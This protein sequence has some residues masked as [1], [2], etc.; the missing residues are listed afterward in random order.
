[1]CM[2]IHIYVC[3]YIDMYMYVHICMCVCMYVMYTL[4]SNVGKCR[5]I[6]V[7][8]IAERNKNKDKR[9]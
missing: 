9:V 7:E 5:K 8:Q 2:Y 3:V 6:K 4:L 1:M